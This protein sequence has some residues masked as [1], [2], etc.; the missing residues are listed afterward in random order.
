M[1][2]PAP[3]APVSPSVSLSRILLLGSAFAMAGAGLVHLDAAGDHTDHAFIATFFVFA[4]VLQ[5]LVAAG[6]AQPPPLPRRLVPAA[7]AVNVGLVAT[8]ALTRTVGLEAIPVAGALPG[9]TGREPVGV[10]DLAATALE[11]SSLLLLALA[12]AA[13]G[14]TAVAPRVARGAAAALLAAALS[15]TVP[16]VLARHQHGAHGGDGHSEAR[17]HHGPGKDHVH[18]EVSH[19]RGS[20]HD[21]G[22]GGDHGGQGRGEHDDHSDGVDHDDHGD[23]VDHNDHGD[24]H[25]HGNDGNDADHGDHGDHGDGNDHGDHTGPENQPREVDPLQG[26]GRISTVRVGPI[27][28]PPSTILDMPH[29]SPL[30]PTVL[31]GKVNLLPILG[32]KPPCRD[33]YLL[34]AQP[35]LVYKDG[36]PANLDTGPMLHHA[37]IMDPSRD[38]P[39]CP[40]ATPGLLGERLF[41]AG[42]ERT[43]LAMPDGYGVPHGRGPFAG[44]IELMNTSPKARTV[45]L[46]VAVRWVPL[47]TPGIKPVRP[48]WFDIDS[49]GDSEV[50]VDKGVTDIRWDWTS[51][52]TG[53]L[54]AAG[55]HLHDGG[56][57]LALHNASTGQHVCT[58]VA[59]YGRHPAYLGTLDTMTT[60]SWD[61]L[62]SVR[63]GERFRL[64]AHYN[65]AS[66][67][68]GV[69]G[70]MMGFLYE[71]RDLDGGSTSPYPSQP[72]P[73]GAP[74]DGGGHQ[75]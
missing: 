17:G 55:G 60:C 56:E 30:I 26:P 15:L 51:S 41:A 58:S 33:C 18:S 42:N 36:S 71:T 16:G 2:E 5:L 63:R 9:A 48:L 29:T 27:V 1:S 64:T 8:W 25:D 38:D 12:P 35:D 66:P 31:P 24:G 13:A 37:V 40:R 70:I 75:H 20:G 73:D 21:H 52:L 7:V 23:G 74:P 6:V 53:R 14:A 45:Y 28:V 19:R 46:E 69:M 61:S 4:G 11:V 47:S 44:A 34:G 10:K 57:W 43:G 68:R 67:Q 32:I 3:P 72:P 62:G 22:Q 49:C 59:G 39:I 54:V 50:N 65:T